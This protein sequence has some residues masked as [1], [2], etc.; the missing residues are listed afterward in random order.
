ME[1]VSFL[2]RFFL[3]SIEAAVEHIRRGSVNDILKGLPPAK[4][5]VQVFVFFTAVVQLMRS[6]VFECHVLAGVFFAVAEFVSSR[7][8]K[9]PLMINTWGSF[10]ESPMISHRDFKQCSVIVKCFK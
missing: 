2:C 5:S 3:S 7:D 9:M 4:V 10:K 1:L 8:L 6:Q